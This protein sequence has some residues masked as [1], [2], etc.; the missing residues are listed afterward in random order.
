MAVQNQLEIILR[1][2]SAAAYILFNVLMQHKMQE[3]RVLSEFSHATGALP[4]SCQ[5][6]LNPY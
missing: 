5:I 3:L 4:V 1:L 2:L 6:S